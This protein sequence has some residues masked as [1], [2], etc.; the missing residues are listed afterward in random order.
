MPRP[1][2]AKRTATNCCRTR[3]VPAPPAYSHAISETNE[4][5]DLD[6]VI[7]PTGRSTQTAE[8]TPR[9]QNTL[10]TSNS[11]AAFGTRGGQDGE[12]VVDGLMGHVREFLAGGADDGVGVGV[13][14][15]VDGAQHRRSGTGDAQCDRTQELR[16]IGDR[17]PITQAH[18]S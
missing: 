11:I 8:G 6:D 12:R 15:L 9:R 18:S 3:F 1:Q 7:T 14:M 17:Y 5:P 10:T 16:V 4:Q 13:R 2:R